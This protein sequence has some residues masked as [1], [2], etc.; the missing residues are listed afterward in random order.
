MPESPTDHSVDP[1]PDFTP[2]DEQGEPE[3]PQE[4]SEFTD[5]HSLWLYQHHQQI[6]HEVVAGTLTLE[7][8]AAQ[9]T[10]ERLRAEKYARIDPLTDMPNRAAF[11]DYLARELHLMA[12]N[13]K[14]QGTIAFVDVDKLKPV[15]DNFGHEAGDTLLK[16]F[17]E[18]T[19]EVITESLK[20]I[21]LENP[22]MS[23]TA[24]RIGGD[25]FG[26]YFGCDRKLAEVICHLLQQK[27]TQKVSQQ[28]PMIKW[29]Q[30]VSIGMTY[31]THES[32][33]EKAL[34][35]AD[36]AM[37]TAKEEKGRRAP[38]NK[39]LIVFQG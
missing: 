25:E 39:H 34:H 7:A 35:R 2:F 24:A 18:A 8:A 27:I 15:N 3:T 1:T 9:L 33:I 36:I 28:L 30:T 12:V 22:R 31:F 32:N 16:I 10:N 13:H 19:Q 17:A 6:L 14:N 20:A 21:G 23:A 37:Y 26:L 29:E 5:A 11:E 38:E 4:T